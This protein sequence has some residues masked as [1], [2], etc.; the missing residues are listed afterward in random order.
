MTTN[1]CGF[2][3]NQIK[4]EVGGEDDRA[5]IS[6][7]AVRARARVLSTL[8]L[9]GDDWQCMLGLAL[10]VGCWCCMCPLRQLKTVCT[11]LLGFWRWR[12]SVLALYD[13]D[14]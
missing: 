6:C 2:N 7:H 3:P 14:P 9:L 4:S 11:L 1:M 13:G 8:S 12:F 5:V 10:Y